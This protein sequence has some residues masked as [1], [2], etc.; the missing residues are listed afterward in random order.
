MLYHKVTQQCII[1]SLSVSSVLYI[2]HKACILVC[3]HALLC[4]QLYPEASYTFSQK[5]YFPLYYNNGLNE[6]S[7][8]VRCIHIRVCM[9]LIYFLGALFVCI[10]YN[11]MVECHVGQEE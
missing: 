2:S 8:F 11:G 3:V 6:L 4:H 7:R 9:Y 10:D 5:I 1:N